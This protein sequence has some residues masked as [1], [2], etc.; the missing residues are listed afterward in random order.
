MGK[1]QKV[2][3]EATL[4]IFGVTGD[5]TKRKLMTAL[6]ELEKKEQLPKVFNI[7]GFAR[8]PWND[9]MLIEKM[10]SGI[11]EYGRNIYKDNHHVNN[12]LKNTYYVQ[13]TFEDGIGYKKNS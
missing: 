12:L 7:I 13:S 11:N 8:R 4:I 10:H 2:P 5:L 3:E 1:N 6:Y 9:E